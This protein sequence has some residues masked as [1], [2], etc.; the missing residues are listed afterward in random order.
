MK[1]NAQN[2]KTGNILLESLKCIVGIV[3]WFHIAKIDDMLPNRK[4][5]TN[6]QTKTN[7]QTNKQTKTKTKTKQKTKRKQ[8]K[9]KQNKQN[10]QN[11]SV[12]TISIIDTSCQRGR[13]W[14]E[15][16]ACRCHSMRV[17][18]F[19]FFFFNSISRIEC[20]QYYVTQNLPSIRVLIKLVQVA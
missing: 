4:K 8:N 16:E 9:R 17:F 10:D 19:F 14:D 2:W 3:F 15:N 5:Q 7:K 18:F 11:V 20:M 13:K 6:K 1:F 12:Y